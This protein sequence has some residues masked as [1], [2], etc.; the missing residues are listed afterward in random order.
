MD[1][2]YPA[3]WDGDIYEVFVPPY[4]SLCGA[5]MTGEYSIGYVSK[6]LPEVPADMLDPSLVEQYLQDT[7]S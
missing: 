1:R 6:R 3:M 5:T 4:D 7:A 2:A